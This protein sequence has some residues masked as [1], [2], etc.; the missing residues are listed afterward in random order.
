MFKYDLVR[1]EVGMRWEEVEV[2]CG[3]GNLQSKEETEGGGAWWG[4]YL[5][6]GH[7]VRSL[8][9]SHAVMTRCYEI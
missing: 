5:G 8:A 7:K 1:C 4:R 3:C 6:S 9:A 2:R